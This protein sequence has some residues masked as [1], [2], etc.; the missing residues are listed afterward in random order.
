VNVERLAAIPFF[1]K[2]PEG[3]L[4]AIAARAGELEL[5]EGS[6]I[7]AE[8]EFGHCCFAIEEGTAEVVRDGERLRTLQAG[9]VVGEVAVLHSGRRSATVVATTPMRLITL[10]KRDVWALEDEAPVAVQKL[11]ELLETRELPAG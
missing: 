10:F 8:G 9:D 3:E 1:A 4:A 11:G 5:D 7:T 2:L 6:V